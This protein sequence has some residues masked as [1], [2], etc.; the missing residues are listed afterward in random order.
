MCG[1][2]SRE[3][4]SRQGGVS[5]LSRRVGAGAWGWL[6]R[7]R[8]AFEPFREDD[9]LRSKRLLAYGE[10]TGIVGICLR[11]G[12]ARAAPLSA[13]LSAGIG[14]YDWEA[15]AI[16]SPAFVVALLIVARFC[17]AAGRP[18]PGVRHAIARLVALGA[19]D[20][21]E[22]APYRRFELAELLEA[23]GYVGPARGAF[24]RRLRATLAP[25]DKPPSAFSGHDRYAL[26]HVVFALC[27]DGARPAGAVVPRAT[28]ERL[29]WLV[30][31]CGR[32]ALAEA[33]L[34]VLAELVVCARLLALDEPWF[35]PAAFALAARHQDADG[36]LP[37]FPQEGDGADARFLA[38]YHA[39]L[40]WAY[41]AR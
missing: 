22:L 32:M 36:S 18:D 6:E 23:G 17:A 5:E 24:V 7:E 31:L 30:A 39:T 4:D 26:T 40:M 20:A 12:I 33:E 35:V 37:T 38:R 1:D 34:D 15:Q 3:H 2:R 9:P 27:A 19:L 10:L 41:A 25:L 29:R 21:L 28:L 14:R 13:F 11:E 8:A 16:R